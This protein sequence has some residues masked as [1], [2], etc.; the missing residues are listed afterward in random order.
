[1][2]SSMDLI[3]DNL[4]D[5]Y[6][7]M[8]EFE[9][10]LLDETI[11]HEKELKR[12][13]EKTEAINMWVDKYHAAQNR[14][15]SLEGEDKA[16]RNIVI[17]YLD[18]FPKNDKPVEESLT[19]DLVFHVTGSYE[20]LVEQQTAHIKKLEELLKQSAEAHGKIAADNHLLITKIERL[21]WIIQEAIHKINWEESGVVQYLESALESEVEDE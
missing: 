2:K 8:K 9:S 1:M 4:E 17:S 6:K 11:E 10:A 3:I 13:L 14:I 18:I 20:T 15:N 19:H 16:I 7:K 12:S 5:A 21:K